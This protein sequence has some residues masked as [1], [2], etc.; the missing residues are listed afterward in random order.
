VTASASDSVLRD[1]ERSGACEW[2]WPAI[3]W[4]R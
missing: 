2:A 4:R 1:R 3:T